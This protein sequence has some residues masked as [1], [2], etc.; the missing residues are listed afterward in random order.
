MISH[1]FEHVQTFL[2]IWTPYA[3]YVNFILLWFLLAG[4]WN[5]SKRIPKK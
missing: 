3:P 4:L 2:L 5:L 1:L